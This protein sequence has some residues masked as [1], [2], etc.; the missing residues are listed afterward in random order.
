MVLRNLN[1][2]S[3][4]LL[5]GVLLGAWITT[6]AADS[7]G[8]EKNESKVRSYTLANCIVTDQKLQPDAHSFKYGDREIKT[9][10]DQC[11]VDF[12]KD[13]E[14]YVEKIEEAEKQERK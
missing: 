5:A 3:G 6:R 4:L 2:V 1:H 13:P 8:K 14:G 12:Y 9:C 7:K 10:C 11:V